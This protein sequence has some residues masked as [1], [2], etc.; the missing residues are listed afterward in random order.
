M[1]N[2]CPADNRLTDREYLHKRH[3][4]SYQQIDRFLGSSSPKASVSEK[5]CQ[6]ESVKKF[7][8][9]TD[10]LRRNDVPFIPLKGCLLSYRIYDDPAVRQSHDID[11]LVPMKD[12]DRT[13]L[14]M[15]ED[16]FDLSDCAVWPERKEQRQWLFTALHHI[17]IYNKSKDLL[18]EIHW[19]LTENLSI[20][21]SRSLQLLSE[22]L[23]EVMFAGRVFT[24]MKPEFELLFL[25]IH[26]SRHGWERLKWLMDIHDYP[27]DSLDMGQWK[28]LA[29]VFKADRI[30]CQ[31][32][33]LLGR[34]FGSGLPFLEKNSA[35]SCLL[36]YPVYRIGRESDAGF[37][38]ADLLKDLYYS[39][40]LFPSLGYKIRVLGGKLFSP[41]DLKNLDASFKLVYYF[42]R[43]YGFIK[44]RLH[45]G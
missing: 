21:T 34:Y 37:S 43:P 20:S 31:A 45:N 2:S 17:V 6:L 3:R 16:G 22:N 13:V 1:I 40:L 14:L 35:P 44:R 23:M 30:I 38:V 36:E 25:M 26:G 39:L 11:L 10:L 4:F 15:K 19:S 28:R 8:D 41:G 27:F 42:Y 32:D 33:Y 7:L 12:L 24:V 5:V 9:L 29:G 18:V